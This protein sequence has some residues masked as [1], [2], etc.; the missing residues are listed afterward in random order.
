VLQCT[1]RSSLAR[2][3]R[4]RTAGDLKCRGLAVSTQGLSLD[5]NFDSHWQDPGGTR[6]W[7]T[8]YMVFGWNL[9]S[10]RRS[11]I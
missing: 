1:Y 10:R 2:S 11:R 5:R 6:I 3:A 8:R 7:Y 9:L 4:A